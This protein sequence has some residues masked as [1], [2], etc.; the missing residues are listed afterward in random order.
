METEGVRVEL[1]DCLP[2]ALMS[3]QVLCGLIL[4]RIGTEDTARALVV[5]EAGVEADSEAEA[6]AAG[7]DTV[8][9]AEAAVVASVE[10]EVEAGARR[11]N[12]KDT[13]R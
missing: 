1:E 11:E 9:P 5:C 6:E 7:N 13:D 4:T 2:T 10:M 8:V 12:G 3:R